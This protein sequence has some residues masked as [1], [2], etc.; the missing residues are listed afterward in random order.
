MLVDEDVVW[1]VLLEEELVSLVVDE[2]PE[3]EVP[4]VVELVLIVENEDVVDG[5]EV[6][7]VEEGTEDVVVD[8]DEVELDE[9]LEDELEAPEAGLARNAYAPMPATATTMMIITASKAGARP[10]L[11]LSTVSNGSNSI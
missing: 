6:E 7:V 1:L 2:E 9:E 4:L 8:G 5:E 11:V 3:V 10:P